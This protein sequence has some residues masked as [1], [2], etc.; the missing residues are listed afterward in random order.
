MRKR[1]VLL[2]LCV[3]PLFFLGG[4]LTATNPSIFSNGHIIRHNVTVLLWYWPFGPSYSLKG[5]VCWDRYHIPRCRLTDQRSLYHTA[6]IVV[7]HNRELIEGRQKLPLHLPRSRGQMWVWMSLES[8]EN[9]GDLRPYANVFNLTMSYRRD[10]DIT[11]SYGELLPKETGDREC[12]V[13]GGTEAAVP[14][15]KSALVCWVVS[16]YKA[17]YRRSK[18]Y[19]NLNAVVPVTVYG[20]WIKKW[21]S[22]QDLLPTISR[23]YFY[24]AFENS[25]SKDYITE[26]LWRNAYQA[27]AVPI[28]LGPSLNYYKA[29]APP[30]SFIHVDEFASVEDLGKYLKR[31][32]EDKESYA[33]YFSWK[34]H[35]KVKLHT[36]WRERLCRICS[37]YNSLPQ[38]K[39]YSDL[40]AWVNATE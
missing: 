3:L 32:A 7:F 23:C 8:P 20:R 4:W 24:L 38:Q 11:I 1:L 10:A 9:N 22:S 13:E 6:D 36:D 31:L 19:N 37:Q 26:K 39:I 16:N 21:L 5:D 30:N 2:F 18:V 15:N 34:Q 40:E 35:W 27:G 12:G 33:D 28:V 25:V 17:H 29:V 14:L